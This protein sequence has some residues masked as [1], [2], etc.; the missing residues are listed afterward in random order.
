MP[1]GPVRVSGVPM[2]FSGGSSVSCRNQ[3]HLLLPGQDLLAGGLVAG[4]EPAAV[5]VGPL[6]RHVVRSVRRAGR[7]VH[8]ERPVRG[9]RLH[10]VDELDRAVGEV[11]REVVTLL[12]GAGLVDRVVVV[13]Q[14]R[15]P[16]VGLR[17]EETVEAVEARGPSGQLRRVEARFISSSAVR[18]HLPTAAVLKPWSTSISATRGALGRDVPVAVGEAGGRLGDAGHPVRRVVA[19]GQQARPGRRA[20]GG[21]VPLGVAQTR[22]R[23]PVDVRGV[24]QAAITTEARRSPRRPARCRARSAL[25]AAPSAA[26]TAPSP[27]PSRGCRGSRDLGTAR[28]CRTPP[29][30]DPSLS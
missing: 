16:L 13:D 20:Q 5:A 30:D 1:S 27:A 25:P 4:V 17:A 19:A 15:I 23:D 24:D 9:D 10:V 18:C 21:R 3:P 12:R 8:E 22:R 2:G 6:P 28:T 29:V 14:V 26:R 7:V 11:D